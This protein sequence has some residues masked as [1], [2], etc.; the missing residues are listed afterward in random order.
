MGTGCHCS[1]GGGGKGSKWERSG[2]KMFLAVFAPKA[3]GA[4]NMHVSVAQAMID[5]LL[6]FSSIASTQLF[7]FEISTAFVVG[8]SVVIYSVFL[9]GER[10]SCCGLLGGK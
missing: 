10:A 3:I 9:Y 7:G 1:G 2:E 8:C 4:F 5:S 6:F